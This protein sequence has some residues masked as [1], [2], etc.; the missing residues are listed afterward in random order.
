MYER[1]GAVQVFNGTYVEVGY[2]DFQAVGDGACATQT[3]LASLTSIDS[4]GN[5]SSISNVITD[6]TTV[7][8]I[9][10]ATLNQ[11]QAISALPLLN[12]HNIGQT[13]SL[14]YKINPY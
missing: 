1:A 13:T 12:R 10:T 9:P 4:S 7:S 5:I 11:A 8:I 2:I 3:V 14:D 6:D